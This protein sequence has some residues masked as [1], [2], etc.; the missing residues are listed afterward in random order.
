MQQ[1]TKKKHFLNKKAPAAFSGKVPPQHIYNLKNKN[2]N[3]IKKSRQ[4]YSAGKSV[5]T[6]K[7][8]ESAT[9][10][11]RRLGESLIA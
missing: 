4:F 11:M 7:N 8:I 5:Q 10:I 3:N 1:N 6:I 2:R 9:T